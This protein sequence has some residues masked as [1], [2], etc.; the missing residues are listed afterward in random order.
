MLIMP[1]Q[2]EPDV[3][4]PSELS[5]I[6]CPYSCLRV[7]LF[8]VSRHQTVAHSRPIQVKRAEPAARETRRFPVPN[9]CYRQ[10][11]NRTLP[12]RQNLN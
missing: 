11:R 1:L 8:Q 10:T 4:L 5:E 3:P 12:A 7:Q 9:P 2:L 6:L